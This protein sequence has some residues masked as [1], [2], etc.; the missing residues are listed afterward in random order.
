MQRQTYL[1]CSTAFR[2]FINNL[3]NGHIINYANNALFSLFITIIA[4][5]LLKSNPL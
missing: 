1:S 2:I 3:D 4:V 5:N